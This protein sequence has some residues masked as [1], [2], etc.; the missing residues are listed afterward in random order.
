M[1][2]QQGLALSLSCLPLPPQRAGMLPER[3]TCELILTDRGFD[4]VS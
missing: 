1:V 3:E 4:P 2:H